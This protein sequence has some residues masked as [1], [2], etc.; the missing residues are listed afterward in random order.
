M[1]KAKSLKTSDWA[2]EVAFLDLPIGQLINSA[3]ILTNGW[4]NDKNQKWSLL[5]DEIEIAPE[6][7]QLDIFRS[8][9]GQYET[10][11]LTK[12]AIAPFNPSMHQKFNSISPAADHDFKRVDL[13]YAKKE[14]G[15]EFSSDIS[16]RILRE[17]GFEN[18]K[19]ILTTRYI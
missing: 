2:N 6:E 4:L 7:I 10:P 17:N 8:T 15:Y 18:S 12:V 14:D 9:R 13:W 3:I 19:N 11:I 5:F 1:E 16:N